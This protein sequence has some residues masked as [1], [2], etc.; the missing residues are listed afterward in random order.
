MARI[1]EFLEYYRRVPLFAAC[2]KKDLRMVAAH[3]EKV[4]AE[5][6]RALTTE[7]ESGREFFM[8]VEGNGVVTR[9]GRR[10]GKVGPG[11]AF[12]ELALLDGGIRN[13]TVVAQT[14]MELLV[15]TR[16]SFV[17][18]LDDA[19]GFATALLRGVARRLQDS[20]TTVGD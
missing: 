15:L 2:S 1:D 7:G 4:H 17:K 5:A 14:P 8:V 10:V 19:P 18:M 13:A 12:G 9:N 11:D 20:D 16:P 3:A 6:G